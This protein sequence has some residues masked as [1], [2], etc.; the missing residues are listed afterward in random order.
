[1]KLLTLEK[2]F[3]AVLR[4]HYPQDPG[5][6]DQVT[7]Y[8]MQWCTRDPATKL[9]IEADARAAFKAY[10][11]LKAAIIDGRVRLHG[12]LDGQ[13][14]GDISTADIP[15]PARID[16]F[17]NMLDVRPGRTYH[18]V[19]CYHDDVAALAGLPIEVAPSVPEPADP[20]EAA[21]ALIVSDCGLIRGEI[22]A[23]VRPIGL[24]AF[25]ILWRKHASPQQKAQGRRKPPRASTPA[26]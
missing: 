21:R 24:K 25:N 20:M 11:D 4:A 8:G 17:G 5:L 2:S 6:A 22:Y 12:C 23:K 19:C 3:R 10:D 13:P 16:I 18:N 9:P 15:A 26:P 1:M 14:C 7:L